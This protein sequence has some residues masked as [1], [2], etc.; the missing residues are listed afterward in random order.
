MDVVAGMDNTILS[1]MSRKRARGSGDSNN[2]L[3]SQK[4]SNI[5][6]SKAPIP[7]LPPHPPRKNDG[8]KLHNKSPKVNTQSG[9]RASLLPPRDQGDYLNPVSE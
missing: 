4:K 3:A 8:V 6:P 9:D 1:V 5:N 7:A 2:T